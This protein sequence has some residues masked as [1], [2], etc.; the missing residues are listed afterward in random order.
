[1]IFFVKMLEQILSRLVKKFF[2]NNIVSLIKIQS[3]LNLQNESHL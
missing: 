1:M 3:Y 2:E